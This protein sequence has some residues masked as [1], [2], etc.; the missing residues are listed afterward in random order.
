MYTA[1]VRFTLF[2]LALLIALAPGV[3][4][5]TGR[6]SITGIVSDPTGAAVPGVSVLASHTATRIEYRTLTNEAGHYTIPSLPIGEYNLAYRGSGFAPFDRQGVTLETG[7]IARID[8]ALRLGTVAEKLTVTAESPLLQTET[9]QSSSSVNT[10]IFVGLPLNFSGGRNMAVFADALVPGVQGAGYGMR[11]QG[12]P[13]AS[14]SVVVDGMNV[15]TGR[16]SDFQATSVSP[17]AVQEMTVFTGNANAE[18][19]RG[20]GGSLNFVLKSGTND[21]HGSAFLY[22][23]NEFLNSN[24]WDS[25]LRLAADPEFKNPQ[26]ANFR[27]PAN[28]RKD[29]GFSFGGPVWVPRLYDGR[30]RTFFYFSFEKSGQEELGP[31]GLSRTVPQPEMFDGNLSRLLTGTR[32]GTDILGRTV[33]EGQIYDPLT[34]REINGQHVADPFLGNIIPVS[35]ISK[36]ARQFKSIF[37][38]HY[39]PINSDIRNNSYWTRWG[40]NDLTQASVKIDHA[41]SSSHRFSGFYNARKEIGSAPSDQNGGIWSLVEPKTGGPLSKARTR[42][43][44]APRWNVNYDWVISPSLL[45]HASAGINRQTVDNS[46]PYLGKGLH[47]IWGI[48]GVGLDLP[49]EKVTV[50]MMSLGASPVMSVSSNWAFAAVVFRRYRTYVAN[51]SLTWQKGSHSLKFGAE[52]M[53]MTAQEDSMAN[54]GGTFNFTARTTAIPGQSYTARV[55]N[56]FASFLLGEVDSASVGVPLNPRCRRDAIS[57]FVQDD[58]KATRRLTLNLGLRWS[59]DTP[60]YETKDRI[61]N[62]NPYLPDPNGNNLPGAVEYM[63]FGPG[64]AG[65]RSPSPGYYKNFGPVAGLAYQITP[66]VVLRGSY[67]ITYTP[68]AIATVSAWG[69]SPGGFTAGFNQINAVEANT[70]GMYRSVFNIDNGYPGETRPPD[71]N[72]SW[73]QT[74]ASVRISPELY[75]AG[76]VQQFHFGLQFQPTPKLLVETSWRASKGTRIHSGDS[77]LPN[78]IRKEELQRGAVLGQVIDTPQK[79]AAAGL[80]YPYAGWSGLGANTLQPFPQI[81]TRGLTAYGDPVGFSNYHSGNLIVTRRMS[82]GLAAY[83]AYTFSKSITNVTE[84][85]GAGDTTGFQDSYERTLYKTVDPA[86]RTHV[87][88]ASVVYELPFGRGKAVLKGASGMLNSLV[89][90]WSASALFRYNS[91]TPLGHPSSRNRPVGWN[92]GE[93]LAIFNTPAGGFKRLFDPERFNPWNPNDPGNRFFD[94]AAF[95]DALP[96]Q[97]GNSPLRFPQVRGLWYLNEDAVISKRTQITE[98]VRLEL[99]VEFFNLL[100]RHRFGGPSMNMN[101]SYFGNVRTADGSRTGQAGMRLDW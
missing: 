80:P 64:R 96:Q 66:K 26:T 92:G 62:F 37:S 97:L 33:T 60:A 81:N 67:G 99:R 69:M 24:S 78:Q 94:P 98:K 45:N 85:I 44:R 22:L 15:Q 77:V 49:V 50:P 90:G 3:R 83:A 58:W 17:E 12:T 10:E 32:V 18:F 36:L 41:L 87:L 54:S 59:G 39:A 13:G 8:V 21:I 20:A 46:A 55:G 34:L 35:R 86:D 28:R 11:I 4:G 79:A 75:T 91:A 6:A 48:E 2:V 30:N 56:S 95:S 31:E 68:E 71:L 27:R 1:F 23:Q 93:V 101:D 5:Q 57:L 9:A 70:R 47:K 100:N 52:W 72:P 29:Y 82:Q 88:K 89:S 43:F 16:F 14:Q 74:R 25:N 19:G 42:D 40:K 7:Q 63:G 84:V 76:Y 53:R 61:A 51:D 38:E 65:K 73:G